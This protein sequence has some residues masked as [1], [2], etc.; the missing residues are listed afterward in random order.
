MAHAW[1]INGGHL[2]KKKIVDHSIKNSTMFF[3]FF[4]YLLLYVWMMPYLENT[5]M[6]SDCWML[7]L[8]VCFSTADTDLMMSSLIV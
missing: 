7:A 8:L 2:E 6:A 4:Y 5:A 1:N 3:L